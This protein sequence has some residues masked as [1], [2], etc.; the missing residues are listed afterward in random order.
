MLI[1]NVKNSVSLKGFLEQHGAVFR[2]IGG[3][4]R[5][6]HC[7]C[8]GEGRRETNKLAI[9]PTGLKWR[10]FSCGK[11][12]DVIDAAA[13]IWAIP[14]RDAIR[15]LASEQW[16]SE[17]M[18]VIRKKKP[19][20]DAGA[21]NSALKEALERLQE[22]TLRRVPDDDAVRY[23][24]VERR[25][26]GKILAQAQGHRLLGFLPSDPF[27]CRLFLEDTVGKDLM[28]RAGLWKAEKKMPAIAYRPIVFFFPAGDSAEFR[29][30]RPAQEGERKALRYGTASRPWYWPG[31]SGDGR[32]VVVEGAIDML[33]MVAL[34]FKGDV[35]A[36]PGATVWRPEWFAGAKRVVVCLDPDKAGRTATARIKD[37]CHRMNIPVTDRT[38]NTGDVNDVLRAAA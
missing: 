10:C 3:H 26:P 6:D 4:W 8:C 9:S 15:R 23:L 14:H 20:S 29:L 16:V 33:S 32:L 21:R 18:P 12:G 37:A 19:V 17:A 34:G 13:F 1:E 24:T 30:A 35:L 25:I 31:L 2:E 5:S 22:A 27:E 28:V 7:P 11:G 38:P 36:I